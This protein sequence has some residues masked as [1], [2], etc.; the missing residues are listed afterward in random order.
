MSKA[1][2]SDRE[3]RR[4]NIEYAR[5]ILDTAIATTDAIYQERCINR[6]VKALNVASHYCRGKG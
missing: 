1:I 5:A 2:K 6:A 4:V 3:W